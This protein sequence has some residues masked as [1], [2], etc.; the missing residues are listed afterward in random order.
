MNIFEQIKQEL[1]ESVID[2]TK[3]E[4]SI[5]HQI[6]LHRTKINSFNDLNLLQDFIFKYV[7]SVEI[8]GKGTSIEKYVETKEKI[9]KCSTVKDLKKLLNNIY[10]AGKHYN[11][12]KRDPISSFGKIKEYDDSEFNGSTFDEIYFKRGYDIRAYICE[13][14][15]EYGVSSKALLK[16]KFE[17]L[18]KLKKIYLV[19]SKK[20]IK[21]I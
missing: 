18:D 9:L 8:I 12:E 20:F 19:L 17:P 13:K 10:F 3:E 16:I 2:L 5:S 1:N 6:D 7:L 4:N 11:T 14:L 15:K 21:I